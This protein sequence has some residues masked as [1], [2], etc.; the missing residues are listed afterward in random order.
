M[1]L[2]EIIAS[3]MYSFAYAGEVKL[4]KGGRAGAALNPLFGRVTKQATYAGQAA[5][6]DMY[7]N[8]QVRLN[9]AW[10]AADTAPR[11]EA[12]THDCVVRSLATGELQVR[13]LNPRRTSVV[14]YYVDGRPATAEETSVIQRYLPSKRQPNWVVTLDSGAVEYVTGSLPD[15]S[16]RF[17]RAVSIRPAVKVMLPYVANLA[18]ITGDLP[19]APEED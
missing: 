6:S 5:T 12:T 8:A 3:R 4:N 2:N 13:I 17:P 19:E 16:A 11:F 9:P 14:S 10:Q 18:N 1:E 15:V 7:V